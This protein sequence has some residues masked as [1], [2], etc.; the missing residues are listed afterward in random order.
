MDL[1]DA[2]SKVKKEYYEYD[3]KKCFLY[4]NN[5]VFMLEPKGFTST[6]DNYILDP[7]VIV[8]ETNKISTFSPIED[9]ENFFKSKII[10]I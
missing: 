9:L 8:D 3:I 2:I 1:K 10:D 5:Y 4:K 7:F 6:R